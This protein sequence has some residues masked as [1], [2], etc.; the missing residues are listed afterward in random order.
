MLA[1][2]EAC[3]LGTFSDSQRLHLCP[4]NSLSGD[5]LGRLRDSGLLFFSSDTPPRA[6]QIEDGGRWSY[7]PHMITWRLAPDAGGASF[8]QLMTRLGVLID[9]RENIPGYYEAV[10]D[11]WNML[12]FDDVSSY[13]SEQVSTFRLSEYRRGPKTDEALR[14]ALERFSIPQVRRLIMSVVKNAAALSM[15]RDFNRRHAM[16]TIPGSLMRWADRATSESWPLY[17]VVKNWTNDEPVLMTLLYDRLIGIGLNGFKSL[18]GT[19]LKNLELIAA[20]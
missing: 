11:L 9:S 20:S 19:G 10:E 18:N 5:L 13:L 1:S 2:D 17:P 4:S 15:S 7:F 6:I 14:Y 3:E 8:P 16:N 12:A